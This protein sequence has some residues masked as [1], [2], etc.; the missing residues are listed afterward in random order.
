MAGLSK[1]R[2][3]GWLDGLG[4]GGEFLWIRFGAWKCGFCWN[5]IMAHRLAG[6]RRGWR[7]SRK[8]EGWA[9]LVGLKWRN[10]LG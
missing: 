5:T 7:P 9:V 4:S 2:W 6:P 8:D 3:A 1:S 10:G